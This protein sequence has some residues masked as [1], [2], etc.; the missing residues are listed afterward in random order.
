MQILT[1][2]TKLLTTITQV[3]W[4]HGMGSALLGGPALLAHRI[5]L[6]QL[7]NVKALVPKDTSALNLIAV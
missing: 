7:Q 2:A 4:L 5:N 3:G 6:L 1:F